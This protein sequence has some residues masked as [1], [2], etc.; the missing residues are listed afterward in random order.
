MAVEESE[1]WAATTHREFHVGHLHTKRT[2]EPVTVD[3]KLGVT[4]RILRSLS[5][6]DAWHASKGYISTRGAEAFV[7]R[8]AGGV[9]ANFTTYVQPVGEMSAVAAAGP[10]LAA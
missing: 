8:K 10:S 4:V 7:Y 1:R 3:D 6:V 2:T 5:G 9:V